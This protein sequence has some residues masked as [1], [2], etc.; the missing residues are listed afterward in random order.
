[1]KLTKNWLERHAKINTS[2]S[3]MIQT[4]DRIGLEVESVIDYAQK[5][6]DFLIAE[7]ISTEQHP[8]A[9][10]LRVCKVNNGTEELQIVCGAA[11]ARAGIKVVLAPIGAEIPD[12]GM[13]IKKSKIRDVESHG[14][15]CSAN[16]LSLSNDLTLKNKKGAEN[17]SDG[18]IELPKDAKIGE[19]FMNFAH[20]DDVVFD[21]AITPNRRIDCASVIGIARELYASGVA[22][23]IKSSNECNS[24][25]SDY[26][27]EHSP[28]N[29]SIDAKDAC[30][31][32]H[33]AFMSGINLG[34]KKNDCANLADIVDLLSFIDESN[35]NPLVNISNFV[36]FDTGRPS[37]MYDAD[38]IDG[39]VHIRRSNVGETFIPLN[40]EKITLPEGLLVVADS[41]KIL[42]V[43]GVIGGEES[44]V[45]ENTKN[46]AIELANFNFEE[47]I[48]S[49]RALNIKTQSSFRFE[50]SVDSGNSDIVMQMLIDYVVNI[51]DGKFLSLL[52]AEGNQPNYVKELEFD[53]TLF[54]T[55][56][57]Y[58]IDNSEVVAILERLGFKVIT[59]EKT[60]T[61]LIVQVPSWR[62][63]DIQ[64]PQDIVEEVIRIKG[65][66]YLKNIDL[67]VPLDA[68]LYQRL[69]K[70]NVKEKLAR[71]FL[72]RGY[73]EVISWSF[74]SKKNADLFDLSDSINLINPIS[75]DLKYMRKSIVPNLIEI[76]K[77]NIV[78]QIEN[79]SIFEI[80]CIY[81]KNINFMQTG[82]IA[83]LRIG[84][85]NSQNIHKDQRKWDFYD[86]RDDIIFALNNAG[87]N[88]D[89][90]AL[91]RNVPKY[92]HPG[93][94]ASIELNNKTVAY[95]GMINP[96]ILQEYK[97]S[98]KN[99]CIFE[100][101]IDNLPDLKEK[102]VKA[103]GK[104]SQF[105]MVKRDFAF[106]VD[107]D[108][109]AG[110]L[111]AEVKKLRNDR[112]NEIIRDV[113][114]FD[115]YYGNDLTD[116]KQ[117]VGINVTLQSDTDTL[118][119][120][121]IQ[122]VTDAIVNKI[123]EKFNAQLRS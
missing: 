20:L 65:F 78:R 49:S 83:G 7:I 30:F 106:I 46:I 11:N 92:Y 87:F 85:T 1:M 17:D 6:K 51:C 121:E 93:C 23:E 69:F 94:S 102:K 38:K 4:L 104:F 79:F 90:I 66:E 52:K 59:S 32:F 3:Q 44:K 100:I 47:V 10:K 67:N 77:Q 24:K 62:Y 73:D 35:T 99:V 48:K 96:K 39:D 55:F 89:K 42:A 18:I 80:G 68:R 58:N 98:N 91:R 2:V 22:S 81:D 86:V 56:A 21:I 82:C 115:I 75:E 95:C 13:I 57:G 26:S 34:S 74:M 71:S 109:E 108:I 43:A 107:K 31:E 122:R 113:N 28:F 63:G 5:Y 84:N 116:G 33:L 118:K 105:Q 15:L 110:E 61:K 72:V 12:N 41:K 70:K 9:D 50:G 54:S 19:K 88:T 25:I 37:H 76:A 97:M 117:S 40:S 64:L 123:I 16:E 111:V 120:H 45:D 14:M 60:A 103:V 8:N 27:K 101:Y 119:E 29:I 36:M 112:Q 114:V 53:T